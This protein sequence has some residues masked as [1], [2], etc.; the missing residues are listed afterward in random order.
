MGKSENIQ[1]A[2]ELAKA[3]YAK[4]GV[5]VDDAMKKLSTFHISMHT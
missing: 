3:Q 1:K 4:L 5:D 2:F